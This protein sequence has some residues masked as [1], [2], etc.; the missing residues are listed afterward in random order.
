MRALRVSGAGRETPVETFARD[1][2]AM[3]R[4]ADSN[5]T[6][7]LRVYEASLPGV[8]LGRYHRRPAGAVALVRRVTGGRPYTIGPGIVCLTG[9]YPSLDW[10]GA[11]NARL[12]PE[13]ALNRALRPLLAI[14]REVGVDAFYPGRDLVTVGGRPVAV[15]SF[16]TLADG[17][18]TM[19][20]ALGVNR[21]FADTAQSI[22]SADPDAVVTFDDAAL[23]TSASLVE[24]L[25]RPVELEWV[26][27]LV[28]HGA[29]AHACSATAVD[30]PAEPTKDVAV[31]FEAL[32]AERLAAAPRTA[33]AYGV[34]MLGAI[35]ATATLEAGRIASLELCGDLI[36]PFGTLEEIGQAMIGEPPTRAAA[37]RALLTVLTRP[38][39]FLLGARDLPGIIARLGD[40]AT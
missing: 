29:R 13:Q 27:R 36:A 1:H 33:S 11:G 7:E 30:G 4:V 21:D 16:T 17:V 38:G 19:T 10:L 3:C 23:A 40:A 28:E 35:E 39:R 18:V 6:A 20:A 12:G 2:L 26:A 5:D 15:A 24:L 37:D 22:R 32:Q 8:S 14:L 31:A 34:E 25:A 9:V